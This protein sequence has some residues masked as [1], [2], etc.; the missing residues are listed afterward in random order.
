MRRTTA[1]ELRE[2]DQI[3]PVVCVFWLTMVQHDE[4]V[5][6]VKRILVGHDDD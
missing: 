1:M 6:V 2:T 4:I 3:K 5:A